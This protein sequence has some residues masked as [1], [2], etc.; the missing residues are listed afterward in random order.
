MWE[1]SSDNDMGYLSSPA[2]EMGLTPHSYTDEYKCWWNYSKDTWFTLGTSLGRNS[3]GEEALSP[4]IKRTQVL[5][6]YVVIW[7][8]CKYLASTICMHISIIMKDE[9]RTES[10]QIILVWTDKNEE[11]LISLVNTSEEVILKHM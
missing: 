10:F 4:N 8:L 5:L 11:R 3:P 6:R 1:D 7:H 9:M 2:L